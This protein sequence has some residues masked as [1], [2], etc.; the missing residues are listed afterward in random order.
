MRDVLIPKHA[1]LLKEHKI[2]KSEY[3]QMQIRRWLIAFGFHYKFA[4]KGVYVDGHERPDV[5]EDRV[6]YLAML[7]DEAAFMTVFEDR[8]DDRDILQIIRN[9]LQAK[10]HVTVIVKHDE[11]STHVNEMRSKIWTDGTHIALR[12]KSAGKLHNVSG[13]IVECLGVDLDVFDIRKCGKTEG[14]WCCE[15]LLEQ[16]MKVIPALEDKICEREEQKQYLQLLFIFDHST[17]HDKHAADALIV[18]R[19]N[20]KP[21]GKVPV[22]RD[23]WYIDANGDRVVQ[24]MWLLNENGVQVPKGLDLVLRER[25]IEILK[26]WR[27]GD[28]RKVLADY[29][30]FKEQKSMLHAYIMAQGH[31]CHFLP[32]FHCELNE[33]EL[34][35]AL[36]KK[37]FKKANTFNSKTHIKRLKEAFATITPQEVRNIFCKGRDYEKAYRNGAVTTTVERFVKKMKKDRK[38]HR[39]INVSVNG[40]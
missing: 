40:V 20:R 15:D 38:S 7:E 11:C 22:M 10:E 29:D 34:I 2:Y 25:G 12:P 16:V 14:Y 3:G 32:K 6:R 23:G 24:Q 21:G 36:G 19:M 5:V 18:N 26:T 1:Q 30:D 13:F 37:R 17:N 31:A 4:S 9:K 39:H 33:M 27:V 35:W 8:N 28:L